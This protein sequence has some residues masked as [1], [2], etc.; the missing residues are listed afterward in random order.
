MALTAVADDEAVKTST[1]NALIARANSTPGRTVFTT[2]GTFTVPA[3]V[4]QVKVYL[5]GGAGVGA[6]ATY[7]VITDTFIPG[8]AGKSSPLCS[9]IIVGLSPGA[10]ISV[11]IGAAAIGAAVGGNSTF[12]TYLASNGSS[13]S[14]EGT[15]TGTLRHEN[16][17]FL[18]TA[19][20]GYGQGGAGGISGAG[21]NGADGICV[22]EW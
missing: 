16:S 9:K 20:L 21:Y 1:M 18:V 3:G 15:H 22:I 7:D 2:N 6:S 11:I 12:G 14:T 8:A 4:Y 5:A 10:S 17:M 19:D 13:T